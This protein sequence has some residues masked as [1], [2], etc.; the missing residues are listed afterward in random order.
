[1]SENFKLKCPVC[2][3]EN[4]AD[5]K[6]CSVC[7]AKINKRSLSESQSEIEEEPIP[8][9]E[10]PVYKEPEGSSVD[11][12]SE[13]IEKERPPIISYAD[14][15]TEEEDIISET[16]SLEEDA[17]HLREET[18]DI[19]G[20][21]SLEDIFDDISMQSAPAPEVSD[22]PTEKAKGEDKTPDA[23]SSHPKKNAREKV[24]SSLVS[25]SVLFGIALILTLLSLLAP[26]A[27]TK[28]DTDEI[29]CELN[30]SAL[31]V[32]VM[33]ISSLC[34]MSEY[35][36]RKTDIYKEKE[37]YI[38]K[39]ESE[40]GVKIDKQEYSEMVKLVLRLEL[41]RTT[42]PIK[43][44]LLLG[45]VVA[46][47]YMILSVVFLILS[48][49]SLIFEI[50]RTFNID[51]P[52]AEKLER[53]TTGILFFNLMSAP[54]LVYT[55]IKAVNFG[56]SD[57]FSI[58]SINGPHIGWGLI[59]SLVFIAL[60]SVYFIVRHI[61]NARQKLIG[62][63]AKSTKRALISLIISLLIMVSI[64]L[65]ISQITL[66]AETNTGRMKSE[67]FGLGISDMN[68]FTR[69]DI[70]EYT[71]SSRMMSYDRLIEIIPKMVARPSAYESRIWDVF[72]VTVI[73]YE[74]LDVSILY[75]LIHVCASLLLL[76]VGVLLF[77]TVRDLF[78]N[79][80]EVSTTGLK[81]V[82][83]IFSLIY[84]GLCVA[85][86]MIVDLNLS[87]TL[88]LIMK[89]STGFGPILCLLLSF[90][91]IRTSKKGKNDGARW[92]Y[93]NP[94]ISYSPYVVGYKT[95]KK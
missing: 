89:F 71:Y 79:K 15:P 76:F 87:G 8:T 83:F 13:R 49:I 48:L 93:D 45:G 56:V 11:M 90:V 51:A 72:N 34:S 53:R 54:L 92:E 91:L 9:A 59:V 85:L 43:V 3:A 5:A 4:E 16:V 29:G 7:G 66:S 77:K 30:F 24:F 55:Q 32:A 44:S 23:E 35:Q 12:R 14:A 37:A 69:L 84:F 67:S 74:R 38:E 42:S 18:P 81:V 68:E 47:L 21:A 64:F 1:M 58:F 88:F 28:P 17:P 22:T 95:N 82:T 78:L 70:N 94:D 26:F 50:L 25:R 19:K 20:E 6:F 46:I 33:S 65:P 75:I 36:L 31:D 63:K 57:T 27:Y 40:E 10:T 41:M 61:R 52:R 73:G 86:S 80:G 39:L 2:G 62:K 60:G